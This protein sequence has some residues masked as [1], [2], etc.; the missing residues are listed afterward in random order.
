[1]ALILSELTDMSLAPSALFYSVRE[2]RRF[3]E[4]QRCVTLR[5]VCKWV[6]LDRAGSVLLAAE[7]E[8]EMANPFPVEQVRRT[9][10]QTLCRVHT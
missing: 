6:G 2:S 1:M 8:R 10:H 4:W 9:H 3:T 5:R 7:V